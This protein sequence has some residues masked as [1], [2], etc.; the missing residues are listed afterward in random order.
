MKVKI[1]TT[2]EPNRKA[3]FPLSS[4]GYSKLGPLFIT[5]EDKRRS[6]LSTVDLN[7]MLIPNKCVL[8]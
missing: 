7:K 2:A 3:R 6:I 4:F 8:I 1:S 5:R